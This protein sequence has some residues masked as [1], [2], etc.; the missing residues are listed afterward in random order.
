MSPAF[1]VL[2]EL[3]QQVNMKYLGKHAIDQQ[4]DLMEDGELWYR[5][6]DH[7]KLAQQLFQMN[8][9]FKLFSKDSNKF[10]ICEMAMKFILCNLKPLLILKYVDKGGN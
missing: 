3:I 8:D 5:G 9:D 6:Y 10:S 7:E 2:K 4:K 1:Q